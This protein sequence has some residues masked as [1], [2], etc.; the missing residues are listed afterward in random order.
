[1]RP[2]KIVGVGKPRHTQSRVIN[3]IAN[4]PQISAAIPAYISHR[5]WCNVSACGT[6]RLPC[7]YHCA[8]DINCG[9]SNNFEA[10]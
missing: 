7:P 4:A 3:T 5:L 6:D 10:N 9:D 1:M 2:E 8:E